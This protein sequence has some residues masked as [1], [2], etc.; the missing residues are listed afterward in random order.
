[1]SVKH[2]LAENEDT[3]DQVIVLAPGEAHKIEELERDLL[4]VRYH[5]RELGQRASALASERDAVAARLTSARADAQAAREQLEALRGQLDARAAELEARLESR[6]A[7]LG[8]ERRQ[9]QELEAR[10]KRSDT[11]ITTLL[12]QQRQDSQ[13][14]ESELLNQLDALDQQLTASRE[15]RS[16]LQAQ[17][18]ALASQLEQTQQHHN[19]ERDAAREHAA[20]LEQR[21]TEVEAQYNTAREK[22]RELQAALTSA[23][24][25]TASTAA[26]LS[27]LEQ[28][29]SAVV[30]QLEQAHQIAATERDAARE[31]VNAL[32]Q[33]IAE[34]EAQYNTAQ[35]HARELQAALTVAAKQRDSAEAQLATLEQTQQQ[36][37][38]AL[39]AQLDQAQRTAAAQRDSDRAQIASLE[40]RI[41]ELETE[42]TGSLQQ[43]LEL[44]TALTAAAARQHDAEQRVTQLEQ[45]LHEQRSNHET[46]LARTREALTR[47]HTEQQQA[48]AEQ[49][50]LSDALSQVEQCL[51][52]SERLNQA[53]REDA[54]QRI[55]DAEQAQRTLGDK[56]RQL[57][58]QLHQQHQQHDRLQQQVR[59]R[60][61]KQAT[62]RAEFE[63]E[64]R[65]LR[66]EVA[67]LQEELDRQRSA[68]DP[69][70]QQGSDAPA[71]KQEDFSAGPN[72]WKMVAG[73]SLL[74]GT[75][76]SATAY[77]NSPR[78]STPG[79]AIP[80]VAGSPIENPLAG[81]A[82]IDASL[83][84]AP[85]AADATQLPD[86]PAPEQQPIAAPESAG[87]NQDKPSTEVRIG[88][89]AEAAA[90]L[91][92]TARESLRA[93][94]DSLAADN[95]EF[96]GDP[97]IR[98]QQN[99]LIALGFDLGEARADGF[100][101]KR[102]NQALSEFQL[103]YLP[104]TGK[105]AADDDQQLASLVKIFA[106]IARNDQ[107]AFDID[108]DVLAAIRL[109][110]LRTGMDF[111]YL[112]ELAYT[113]SSFDPRKKAQRSSAAGLFQF[114]DRTWL[115]SIKRYGDKYGLGLY[116]ERIEHITDASG[117]R[118]P[119]VHNPIVREHIL[120][121]RHN[122]RIAT[123]MAAE[124]TLHNKA[125]LAR[126]LGPEPGRTA[127]YLGHFFGVDDAVKFLRRR[128]ESPHAIAAELFPKAAL[129]N[130][131]V[132]TP[133]DDK[134]RTLQE[135][136]D[137]FDAKFGTGHYEILN[138]ALVLV[139]ETGP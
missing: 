133:W 36:E 10:L 122:P 139:Q 24:G 101:G 23:A 137:F 11:R 132:F 21:I 33:R 54:A 81:T 20:A 51:A 2:F 114:T 75:V 77:W 89:N 93:L 5:Y 35:D 97:L 34:I 29:R 25:Q 63:R 98:E 130:P 138:P 69:N 90:T 16:Q 14:R 65:D 108:S 60:R 46:E 76:A 53:A 124:F 59:D 61:A 62:Q 135:V 123:L 105:Q 134:H 41:A 58:E 39:A 26:R 118:R 12:E 1:M 55:A 28:K 80:S 129:A 121:L 8:E 111:P 71:S 94:S 91:Q 57:A 96:R 79:S 52:E 113:E 45:T 9:R 104:V 44:E 68:A 115:D 127:L 119:T 83:A 87:G 64:S 66:A 84:L 102:T 72:S 120:G 56:V 107:E 6:Q 3:H 7:E 106:D 92:S 17:Q 126:Y 48:L 67:R 131:G 27:E 19:A 99:N 85:P 40:Q 128:E 32:E 70:R 78:D 43:A 37:R 50:R 136:Y 109:G 95:L 42:H 116:A 117:K 86:E 18:N 4:A 47:A 103:Y 30:S 88:G 112:M 22:A 13:A 100:K 49:A 73:A 110:S 125:E 31:R 74:L 82:A 15:E 38:S